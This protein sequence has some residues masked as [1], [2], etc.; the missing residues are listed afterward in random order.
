MTT[1]TQGRARLVIDL[2]SGPPAVSDARGIRRST[3]SIFEG[4]AWADQYARLLLLSD[5]VLSALGAGGAY[6]VRFG[7]SAET[8]NT[9]RYGLGTLIFPFAFVLAIGCDRGYEKRYI[10]TGSEEYR[11]VF[12]GVVRLAA[13]VAITSVGLHLDLA[14]GYLVVAFPLSVVLCLLGR[15]SAR[16]LLERQRRQGRCL[17]RVVAVGRERSVAELIRTVRADPRSGFE[18]VAACL[19]TS[20]PRDALV[21]GVPV[22][23]GTQASNVLAAVEA[24]SADTVA[25]TA[26]SD[27]GSTDVRQLSWQL[28]GCDVSMLVAPRVTDVAGPRIHVRPVAGLPLLHVE[29]PELLGARRALK[30]VVDRTVAL[31]MLVALAPLLLGIALLIRVTSPGPAIFRQTRVGT[32]GREFT[33]WKF[34]T[35]RKTAEQEL[36]AL[37]PDNE[38]DGLLFK[39]RGDP[40]ITPTGRWLRRFS[41]DELP[42]LAQVL[43]GRMS[44]VGPR[45]PLPSEVL[46]YQRPVHRRLLVKPGLTGLWQISGRADLSWSDAVRLDLYY[47]ENW[48]LALDV[49]IL[50]RTAAAVL[51][52]K[53]A[54]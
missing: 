34:R 27:L 50:C 53:G 3:R 52:R 15:Y 29:Q 7:G 9:W 8:Y 28:E 4:P 10:G 16:R 54:Y 33:L 22:T 26:F 39:I 21:E 11:R 44:L 14:R 24:S 5:F 25:I 32:A 12:D 1:S 46:R 23:V 35:M 48:S 17:N 40:R 31:V 2:C 13:V 41:L 43:T 49:S 38:Q 18:V 19:D 36:S 30:A 6:L 51:T 47:V 42:Q 20:A 37:M 45:P